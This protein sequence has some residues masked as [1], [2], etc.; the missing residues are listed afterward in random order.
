MELVALAFTS[1]ADAPASLIGNAGQYVKVNDGE[2]ALEFAPPVNEVELAFFTPGVLVNSQTLL[3]YYPTKN[4]E[5]PAGLTGSVCKAGV[6]ATGSTV[7]DIKKNGTNVGT[8]TFAA[9]GTTATLAMASATTFTAVTDKLSIVGPASA[10]ATLADIS[11]SLFGD[12]V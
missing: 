11:G 9:A 4:I 7:L 1:L 3:A 8:L 10:D 12:V 6:A 2:T 5:L